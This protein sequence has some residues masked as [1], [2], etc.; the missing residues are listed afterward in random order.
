[1]RGGNLANNMSEGERSLVAFCY[2]M[3]KL[4]DTDTKGR[5]VFVFIDDPVSSLDANHV[6]FVFSLIENLIAAPAT[7]GHGGYSQLSISTHNLEFLKY[8]EK[9]SKP[10]TGGK[11]FFCVEVD[12]R[13]SKVKSMPR[14]LRQYVT[15]FN[16]L[17]HQIYKC[18]MADPGEEHDCF[19]NFG[20]ILRK[21]L[22]AYLFYRYPCNYE[23]EGS[24][25]VRM[26][27][28]FGTGNESCGSRIS[29]N[30]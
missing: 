7:V 5:D 16:Y 1:M 12:K 24:H 26:R 13:G 19:Y 15:E 3:A 30:Q 18:S 2:F 9:L 27:K 23:G 6:F 21:F 11:E 8:L 17:F 20:N 14:Y 28:F 25:A 22:E 29:L 10:K 4:E